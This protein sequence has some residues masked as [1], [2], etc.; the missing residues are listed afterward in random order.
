MATSP[1]DVL[2]RWI[3]LGQSLEQV[4]DV[5]VDSSAAIPGLGSEQVS[6]KA[7]CVHGAHYNKSAGIKSTC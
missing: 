7:D 1:H 3:D 2:E 5:A 4:V 6:I